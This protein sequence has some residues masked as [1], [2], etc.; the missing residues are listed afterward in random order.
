MVRLIERLVFYNPVV[1]Q[2]FKRIF[3]II[4]RAVLIIW[5]I[6]VGAQVFLMQLQRF[7]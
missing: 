2:I 4:H 7:S 5:D 3:R 6:V 1:T